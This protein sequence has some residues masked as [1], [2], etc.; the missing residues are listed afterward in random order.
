MIFELIPSTLQLSR[1]GQRI[2]VGAAAFAVGLGI[3]AYAS[4]PDANGVIHGCYKRAS[5]ALRVIDEGVA[6]CDANEIPLTWNRTGLVGPAG[7]QGP[8]GLQGP[9][10]PAGPQGPSG[11]EGPQGPEG[12]PGPAGSGRAVTT[13]YGSGFATIPC[14]NIAE[15]ASVHTVAFT[16]ASSNS[17]LRIGYSDVVDIIP[18]TLEGFTWIELKIDG[19]IITPAPVRIH[20]L[21][22]DEVPGINLGYLKQFSIFGYA[23][24]ISAGPHTL[25]VTYNF[26]SFQQR[27]C[28]RGRAVA[29][30]FADSFHIEIEELG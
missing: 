24:N 15:T 23:E 6:Q 4:I 19:S 18:T 28:R 10:G 12:P 17:R 26:S 14:S 22:T 30:N 5:G 1:R 3:I 27:L 9:Q 25:T 16:K 11:P 8:Q 20:L 29:N 7:P 2:A 21:S 13:L